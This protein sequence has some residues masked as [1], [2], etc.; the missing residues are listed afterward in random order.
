MF[1]FSIFRTATRFVDHP[2]NA[3]LF[4][5]FQ[6]LVCFIDWFKPFGV[7]DLIE[8]ETFDVFKLSKV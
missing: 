7:Y 3:S 6:L 1:A 2:I 4:F 5:T 8:L